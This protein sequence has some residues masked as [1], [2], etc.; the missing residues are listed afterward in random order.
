MKRHDWI[1]LSGDLDADDLGMKQ[2]SRRRREDEETP[3]FSEFASLREADLASRIEKAKGDIKSRVHRALFDFSRRLSCEEAVKEAEEEGRADWRSS[4]EHVEYVQAID[5]LR[6]G[7]RM[8]TQDSPGVGMFL[9]ILEGALRTLEVSYRQAETTLDFEKGVVKG[10]VSDFRREQ[11]A[12]I[13][14]ASVECDSFY[15][16]FCETQRQI[17]QRETAI[18]ESQ[19][20]HVSEIIRMWNDC[21]D[22]VAK[23]LRG[24]LQVGVIAQYAPDGLAPPQAAAAAAASPEASRMAEIHEG[25]ANAI[26][27]VDM[28]RV[29]PSASTTLSAQTIMDIVFKTHPQLDSVLQ[30]LLD[31]MRRAKAS[32]KASAKTSAKAPHPNVSRSPSELS[33]S[34][35]DEDRLVEMSAE[36]LTLEIERLERAMRDAYSRA[37]SSGVRQAGVEEEEEEEGAAAEEHAVR[38]G[39]YLGALIKFAHGV[40][41]SKRETRETDSIP[42]AAAAE[43]AASVVSELSEGLRAIRNQIEVLWSELFEKVVPVQKIRDETH[44]LASEFAKDRCAHLEGELRKHTL[45]AQESVRSKV[46]AFSSQADAALDGAPEFFRKTSHAID[47]ICMRIPAFGM[48][49]ARMPSDELVEAVETFRSKIKKAVHAWVGGIHAMAVDF[50]LFVSRCAEEQSEDVYEKYKS[51]KQQ[52]EVFI[53]KI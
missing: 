18:V 50:L 40:L 26:R 17:H 35:E 41:E 52:V 23:S 2:T 15:N 34:R 30:I 10:V 9:S 14:S 11:Y 43:H 3:R 31:K 47:D 33:V 53:K 28:N 5:D 38:E 21:L 29:R 32:A 25:L 45:K 27:F 37:F 6:D 39:K 19:V 46:E 44:E 48:M 20:V 22:Y 1:V 16:H 51:F 8:F 42:M 13:R 24:V 36:V 12:L 49:R 7:K 4:A